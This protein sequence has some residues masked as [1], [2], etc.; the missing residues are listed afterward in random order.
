MWKSCREHTKNTKTNQKLYKHS[1]GATRPLQLYSANNK[2]TI[3]KK[4]LLYNNR[5]CTLSSANNYC[6]FF[7]NFLRALKKLRSLLSHRT[8][9]II[10]KGK[11]IHRQ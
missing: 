3:P 7:V 6:N 1:R 4:N 5:C 10:T 8:I 11:D 2:T 9:R